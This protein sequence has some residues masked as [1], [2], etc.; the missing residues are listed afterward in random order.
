MA[1]TKIYNAHAGFARYV[2]ISNRANE[3]FHNRRA[4]GKFKKHL[5]FLENSMSQIDFNFGNF[6]YQA[7]RV[8]KIPVEIIVSI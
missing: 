6:R 4:S 3:W 5:R 2:C 1:L 8:G 7:R